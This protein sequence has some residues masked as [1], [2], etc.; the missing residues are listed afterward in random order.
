[1]EDDTKSY[2]K[3]VYKEKYFYFPIVKSTKPVEIKR[4]LIPYIKRK[5]RDMKL[6]VEE[7]DE[8]VELKRHF[9]NEQTVYLI[10]RDPETQKFEKLKSVKPKK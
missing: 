1:M 7:L 5:I 10:L 8:T 9:E 6:V 2:I 4:L 3:I